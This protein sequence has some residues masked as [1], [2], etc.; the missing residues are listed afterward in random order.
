MKKRNFLKILIL[1][2]L[3]FANNNF[4]SFFSIKNLT[5]FKKVNSKNSV[6]I[7]SEKD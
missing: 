2:S 1:P 7:L 5:R 6:W 4:L 3:L